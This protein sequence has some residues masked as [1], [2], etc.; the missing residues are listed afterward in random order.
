MISPNG[1]L[2]ANFSVAAS[3]GHLHMKDAFDQFTALDDLADKCKCGNQWILKI[4]SFNQIM[5][6]L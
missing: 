5:Q 3:L 4:K 6:Y 2:I 1:V